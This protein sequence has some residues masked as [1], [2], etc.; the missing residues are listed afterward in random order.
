MQVPIIATPIIFFLPGYLTRRALSKGKS[1]TSLDDS[2]L[3]MVFSLTFASLVGLALA[4][5]GLFSLGNLAISVLFYCGVMIAIKPP[6]LRAAS[7]LELNM[8]RRTAFFIILL[9]LGIGFF[10]RPSELITSMHDAGVYVS[11]AVNIAKSAAILAQDS[12]VA[13]MSEAAL[14]N[15]YGMTT[16]KEAFQAFQYYGFYITDARTG[17]ITPAHFH[18]YQILL[19][20]AYS[21]LGLRIALYVTP[22]LALLS[23]I[24][25]SMVAMRLFGWRTAAVTSLLL[26]AN[27]PQIFFA[28]YPAPEMLMQLLTFAGILAFGKVNSS[29]DRFAAMTS[30]MCFGALFFTRID[31]LIAI[32]PLVAVIAYW[33]LEGKMEGARVYF[34]V[35][36][37]LLGTFWIVYVEQLAMPYVLD[38]L[39]NMTNG[40]IATRIT[41]HIYLLVFILAVC[42]VLGS[43][44]LLRRKLRETLMLIPWRAIRYVAGGA[45]LMLWAYGYFV[46]PATIPEFSSGQTLVVL[47]WYL[48]DVGVALAFLGAALL[49]GQKTS[50]V[51]RLFLGLAGIFSLVYFI[52][53]FNNP[54]FPWCMRRYVTVII[55]SMI[56]L[57]GFALEHI[58][59]V[60]WERI[61]NRLSFRQARR[62]IAAGLFVY[63]FAS[64]LHMSTL[65]L[66]HSD[67]DTFLDQVERIASF[68]DDRD[69][70]L[71]NDRGIRTGISL[72]LKY[73]YGKTSMMMWR[74]PNSSVFVD[75]AK[76]WIDQKRSVFLVDPSD[77]FAYEVSGTYWTRY[78]RSFDIGVSMLPWTLQKLPQGI[79]NEKRELDVYRLEAIPN[80]NA[81]NLTMDERSVGLIKGFHSMEVEQ[82]LNATYR[83]TKKVAFVRLMT[84]GDSGIMIRILF[85]ASRPASVP[86]ANVDIA[87]NDNLLDSLVIERAGPLEF[88]ALIPQA[89]LN[90]ITQT[91]KIAVNTWKPIEYGISPDTREL[92]IAIFRVEM[93]K[94]VT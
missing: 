72:P 68:F 73:V 41:F 64:S 81:V 49:I 70:V 60:G 34:I 47:G 5:Y 86:K 91:L 85:A 78:V 67:Y 6:S 76:R 92:G 27:F 17:E 88:Q 18:L 16:A 62:V 36:L 46:R 45:I 82:K 89:L 15:F 35:T 90:P 20:I 23:T 19:A 37:V 65:I 93:T 8:T 84:Q 75:Q 69:M 79:E 48:T 13:D 1:L 4:M 31:A 83:F 22:L 44:A 53:I 21:I 80:L 58:G 39:N 54:V 50:R 26:V 32:L 2:F 25:V 52:N 24:G 57:V 66:V 10:F 71:C 43:V 63:L 12:I 9:I 11:T 56:I 42:L 51:T 3:V 59:K 77:D 61:N 38:Q 55:P 94:R 40:R 33:L 28:R 74:M 87:V 7:S 29:P 30:A 14:E